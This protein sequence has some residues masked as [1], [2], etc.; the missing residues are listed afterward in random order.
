MRSRIHSGKLSLVAVTCVSVT[1]VACRRRNAWAGHGRQSGG[2]IRDGI[3]ARSP[4]DSGFPDECRPRSRVDPERRQEQVA[5]ALL[6]IGEPEV[7]PPPD[8]T[9]ARKIRRELALHLRSRDA[10]LLRVLGS[11]ADRSARITGVSPAVPADAR[12]IVARQSG[13]ARCL[14]G[15]TVVTGA[16]LPAQLCTRH[17][18]IER[19]VLPPT[20]RVSRLSTLS[21]DQQ[22][23]R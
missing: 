19:P 22:G 12:Q 20:D 13:L 11:S 7:P 16:A 1:L 2:T 17:A 21:A 3:P 18:S 14:R 8:D 6:S 4:A 15:V 10:A 5:A 23:A 9:E